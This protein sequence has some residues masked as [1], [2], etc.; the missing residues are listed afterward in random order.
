M[1]NLYG[2]TPLDIA[3]QKNFLTIVDKL[4]AAGANPSIPNKL[5][6]TPLLRAVQEN[7]ESVV[8]ALLST[9]PPIDAVNH[10]RQIFHRAVRSA[11]LLFI[12]LSELI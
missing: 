11:T 1:Q 12:E 5:G 9:H 6:K 8:E 3:A 4:L 10:I 7:Q 2:Q